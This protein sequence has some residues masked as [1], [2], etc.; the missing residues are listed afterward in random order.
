MAIYVY[1]IETP[2]IY[3]AMNGAVHATDREDGPGGISP[4]LRA[5]MP[6]IK[7]L[8]TALEQLP[9]QFRFAKVVNRGVKW[10][11]PKPESHD[12]MAKFPIG[13]FLYWYEFKSSAVDFDV[14]CKSSQATRS[15]PHS[16]DTGRLLTN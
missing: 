14:M 9:A 6:Y 3:A 1:T 2:K 10:A 15:T 5:C 12:P 11:Y 8:D 7:F 16:V 13:S 4:R